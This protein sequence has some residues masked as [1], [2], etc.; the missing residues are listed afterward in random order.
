MNA[1]KTLYMY[2]YIYIICM[3]LYVCIEI[4][5]YNSCEI[6]W[7]LFDYTYDSYS[8]IVFFSNLPCINMSMWTRLLCTIPKLTRLWP[9]PQDGNG[10]TQEEVD[11]GLQVEELRSKKTKGRTEYT[12]ESYCN[13]FAPGKLMV[14]AQSLPFE[15]ASFQ[16]LRLFLG[17]YPR[18][19][20]CVGSTITILERKESPPYCLE[21]VGTGLARMWWMRK[22][23][24]LLFGGHGL[25]GHGP[26]VERMAKSSQDIVSL[27][28]R[29][30]GPFC[31]W[32]LKNLYK[33]LL[34]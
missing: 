7:N 22:P 26:R 8:P 2:H 14:G 32:E 31:S 25:M 6:I 30:S 16:V 4:F 1:Q 27:N 34:G 19:E 13:I 11:A 29:N 5:L 23:K 28:G 17:G 9:P 21:L 3:F 18:A 12:P 33:P 15:M 24:R 10:L 20:A